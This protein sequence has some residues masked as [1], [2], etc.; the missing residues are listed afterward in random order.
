MCAANTASA[1]SI[2]G[3]VVTKVDPDSDAADKGLQP[4][5][6]I[7][8]IANKPVHSPQDITAAIA[9]AKSAGRS[10]VTDARAEQRRPAFRGFED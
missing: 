3:V 10:T 6:V 4:G 1:N 2:N 9:G 8:T 7:A 5:D